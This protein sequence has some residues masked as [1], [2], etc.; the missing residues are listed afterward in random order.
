MVDVAFTLLVLYFAYLASKDFTD[1]KSIVHRRGNN[2]QAKISERQKKKIKIEI[3]EKLI[4][5][6][7]L[8][9]D[10]HQGADISLGNNYLF[11]EIGYCVK[12]ILFYGFYHLKRFVKNYASIKLNTPEN[13]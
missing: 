12:Q 9:N 13:K 2:I 7:V 1:T 4:N 6:T 8:K 3:R 10:E 5:S 11:K